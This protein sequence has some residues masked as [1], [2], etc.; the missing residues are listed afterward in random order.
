MTAAVLA[1]RAATLAELAAA[2]GDWRGFIVS[3]SPANR[4]RI[5]Q[6]VAEA[7]VETLLDLE[8]A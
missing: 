6:A 7:A 8:A 2:S 1:D 4:A 3:L 5:P